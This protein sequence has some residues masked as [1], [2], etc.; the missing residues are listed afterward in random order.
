MNALRRTLLFLLLAPLA[1]AQPSDRKGCV[2]HPLFTRMPGYIILSCEGKDFAQ[3]TF[4]VG[5][6]QPYLKPEG[7]FTKVVYEM[8]EASGVKPASG[9]EV[10]RNHQNAI[11]AI[12]GEIVYENAP[13]GRTVLRLV[14]GGRETL[15][16]V[17]GFSKQYSLT[18]V[19]KGGMEQSVKA[20]DISTALDAQGR[21]ALYGITFD[22]NKADL[23]PESE[24]TLKM[25]AEVLKA[26]PAL[27][28][29]IVGHTDSVGDH[30]TNLKLSKAR[31]E[32]VKTALTT[33]FGLDA[34]RLIADGVAAMCPVAT[35]GTE[36]GRALNRRVEMVKR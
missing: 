25:M 28:V 10:M 2:D 23:K 35:N 32:A 18:F 21:I 9:L 27:S 26:S 12:G 1:F 4:Y 17:A 36:A 5:G 34:K 22:F 13:S 7:K 3:A 11:K 15:V 29:F 19:E 33:R 8:P 31:A 16:E 20:A 30:A 6:K 14:K 24:A